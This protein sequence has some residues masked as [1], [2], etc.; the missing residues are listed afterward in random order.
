MGHSHG[1][2]RENRFLDLSIWISHGIC[3]RMTDF[4]CPKCLSFSVVK[5]GRHSKDQSQ[6]LICKTCS[7]HFRATYKSKAYRRGVDGTI[8][9][10]SHKGLSIRHIAKKL[11]ISPTTVQIRRKALQAEYQDQITTPYPIPDADLHVVSWSGGKDSSAVLAWAL[12]H[13]PRSQTRFVFC[14]TGW[15]SPMTYDFINQVNRTYLHGSLIVLRSKRYADL[16]DLA[17]Q[18]KRFP[19]VKARFCTEQL[20][21]V[22]MIDWLLEQRG[23]LAVYQ[24]IRARESFARSMMAPSDHY[25]KP[26]M[27]YARDRTLFNRPPLMYRRVMTWLAHSSCCVERPFFHWKSEDVLAYCKQRGILNPLYEMG[28]DRVG[29]WPCIMAKK[30]DIR[31][32]SRTDPDRIEQLAHYEQEIGSTFFGKG[33]VPIRIKE[34]PDIHTVVDWS[35]DKAPNEPNEPEEPCNAHYAACE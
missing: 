6:K 23:T 28:F 3:I 12:E 25:F 33:K 14:D 16:V 8:D 21:I 19:S 10:L 29:C 31:T 35:N 24:G 5:N 20:K 13:L 2:S 27:S 11:K 18:K 9:A 34:I 1:S 30:T 4:R 22:P 17:R 32:L 15:E 26:Q 7:T